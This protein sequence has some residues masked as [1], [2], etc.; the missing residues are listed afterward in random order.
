MANALGPTSAAVAHETLEFSLILMAWTNH[1]ALTG[2]RVN[3]FDVKL[4]KQRDQF[5]SII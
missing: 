2:G 4:K 1:I 3:C 5:L